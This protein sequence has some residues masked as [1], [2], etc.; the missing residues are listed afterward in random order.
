MDILQIPLFIV[1][2][3]EGNQRVDPNF[4]SSLKIV[5]DRLKGIDDVIYSSLGYASLVWNL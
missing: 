4:W 3:I 5:S 2:L 1:T